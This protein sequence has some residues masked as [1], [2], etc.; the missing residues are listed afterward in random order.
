M[1]RLFGFLSD[2]RTDEAATVERVRRRHAHGDDAASGSA[3]REESTDHDRSGST[4][5]GTHARWG[6]NQ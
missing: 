4:A 2:L 1:T 6:G 3:A 5:S